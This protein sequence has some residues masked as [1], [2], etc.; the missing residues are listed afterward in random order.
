MKNRA[1]VSFTQFLLFIKKNSSSLPLTITMTLSNSVPMRLKTLRSLL[2]QATV[3]I[4]HV[5]S[6]NAIAC[7][8][9]LVHFKMQHKLALEL[10]NKTADS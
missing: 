9:I 8:T 1:V 6:S 7:E 10:T 4:L 2:L 3:N 5:S